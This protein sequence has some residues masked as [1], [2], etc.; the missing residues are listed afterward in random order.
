M[1]WPRSARS[2]N[3]PC[4]SFWITATRNIDI[5]GRRASTGENAFAADLVTCSDYLRMRYRKW[6]SP[7]GKLRAGMGVRGIKGRRS[8]LR[9]LLGRSERNAD[10]WAV[11][12]IQGPAS[13]EA[14]YKNWIRGFSQ[15]VG[16]A[17]GYWE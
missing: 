13:E 9:S 4:A 5:S 12:R 17:V 3:S 2:R 16:Y 14:G 11:L 8:G 7:I 6:R 10:R 15:T 1:C